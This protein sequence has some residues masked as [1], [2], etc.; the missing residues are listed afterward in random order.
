MI[1]VVL[2]VPA[3]GERWAELLETPLM[4]AASYLAARWTVRR[5]GVPVDRIA[6]RLG[7]GLIGLALLLGAEIGVVLRL[8]GLSI[9][10]YVAGRDPVSGGVYVLAL[11]VFSV[12]PVF[13]GRSGAEGVRAS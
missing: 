11:L 7:I 13:A 10:E 5:F 6:Q 12:M 4:I 9:S 1:R 2:V 8:R 3:L